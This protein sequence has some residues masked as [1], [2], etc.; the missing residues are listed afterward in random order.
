LNGLLDDAVEIFLR[1][2]DST[3]RIARRVTSQDKLSPSRRLDLFSEIA[4]HAFR[5]DPKRYGWYK[6]ELDRLIH[7]FIQDVDGVSPK[8]IDIDVKALLE[9]IE[10]NNGLLV[11]QAKDLYTFSHLTFHEFFTARYIA[12][13]FDPDLVREIVKEH[14]TDRQWHEVFII[15]AGRLTKADDLLKQIFSHANTLIASSKALQ[16]MLSWL[17]KVTTESNVSSSSWRAGYLAIDLDITLYIENAIKIDRTLAQKLSTTLRAF[18]KREERIIPRTPKADIE[19]SLGAI[20]AIAADYAS[21]TNQDI[22]EFND[23]NRSFLGIRETFDLESKLQS[24]IQVAEEN[25]YADLVEELL[26]LEADLP[27]NDSPK[28]AWNEW[29][30]ELQAI[31]LRQLDV[32]YEISLSEQDIKALED[33]LYTCNL[34]LECIQAGSRSSRSLRDLVIDSILL[35]HANIPEQMIAC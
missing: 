19:L 29:A 6:W 34:L 11:R 13:S 30:N 4:Y 24:I 16:Q 20:H 1:R 23:Y 28:L 21:N 18:N 8:T 17:D 5:E 26:T 32:G 27:K 31:M 35:P 14:L 2:W 25:D 9:D 10:S 7:E 3:R 12:G 15:L 22:S 33:Y